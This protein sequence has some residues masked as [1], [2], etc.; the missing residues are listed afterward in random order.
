M[1][2]FDSNDKV[3]SIEEKPRQLK[4][5]YAVPNVY[6]YDHEVLEIARANKPSV[7]GEL[8]IIAVNFAYSRRGKLQVRRLPRGF[9]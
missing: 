4:T 8:E 9:A 3:V 6:I 5:S 1:V 7:R 2:E